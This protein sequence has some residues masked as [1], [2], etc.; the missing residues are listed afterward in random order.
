MIIYHK[1]L[2]NEVTNILIEQNKLLFLVEAILAVKALNLE[3]IGV[4]NRC[5][6]GRNL[7]TG[8]EAHDWL[9]EQ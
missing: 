9:I 8:S 1:T 6:R 2:F 7:T 4:D 3:I 5:K